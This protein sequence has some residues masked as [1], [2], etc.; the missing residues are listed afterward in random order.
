MSQVLLRER[1]VSSIFRGLVSRYNLFRSAV[2]SRS[3]P[4]VKCATESVASADAV[5]KRTSVVE[6][7][8]RSITHD[9]IAKRAFEI[10]LAE[11]R[12]DGRALEHWLRAE[13]ELEG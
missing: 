11:G 8:S 1:G 2:T 7:E 13:R 10:W 5:V 6:A 4:G 12:E 3:E 9:D